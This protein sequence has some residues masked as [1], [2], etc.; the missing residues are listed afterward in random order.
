[1]SQVNNTNTL[2]D[3][4]IKTVTAGKPVYEIEIPYVEGAMAELLLPLSA[5]CTV[6]ED[7]DRLE[8][9]KGS[10]VMV[11]SNSTVSIQPDNQ[12]EVDI[13]IPEGRMHKNLV[14]LITNL[15]VQRQKVP[16][17]KM[18]WFTFGFEGHLVKLSWPVGIYCYST[19]N[20]AQYN[21]RKVVP[22]LRRLAKREVI[23][24]IRVTGPVPQH[25]YF[26]PIDRSE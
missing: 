2:L 15:V 17:Q 7:S 12:S 11:A 10:D 3:E 5:G 6:I 21:E 8:P 25:W 16:T 24:A 9:T 1:M 22:A 19:S 23:Q 4:Y 13:L 14:D 26:G 18:V 20:L